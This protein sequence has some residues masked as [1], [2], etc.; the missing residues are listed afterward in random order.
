[1]IRDEGAE[2]ERLWTVVR[3]F[4]KGVGFHDAT[5]PGGGDSTPGVRRHLRQPTRIA[6][7]QINPSDVAFGFRP[8]IWLEFDDGC[9]VCTS[10][11]LARKSG[12]AMNWALDTFVNVDHVGDVSRKCRPL[13]QRRLGQAMSR[14]EEAGRW[15]KPGGSG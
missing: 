10:G 15:E 2:H 6:P 1:M 13:N 14:R 12:K 7:R 11:R 5:S 9:G 8:P 3:Q 4:E